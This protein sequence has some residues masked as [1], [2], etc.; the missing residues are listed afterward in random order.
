V[1]VLHCQG[2]SEAKMEMKKKEQILRQLNRQVIT[3]ESEKKSLHINVGDAEK[4]LRT[5]AR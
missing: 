4:A 2:L 3:M 1:C 5:A